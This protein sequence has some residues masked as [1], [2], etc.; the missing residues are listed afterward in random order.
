[1]A[2]RFLRPVIIFLAFFVVFILNIN[3]SW[4]EEVYV[5]RDPQPCLLPES[6]DDCYLS[7]SDGLYYCRPH[8]SCLDCRNRKGKLFDKCAKAS[9]PSQCSL[10]WGCWWYRDGGYFRFL[11]GEGVRS[12]MCYRGSFCLPAVTAPAKCRSASVLTEAVPCHGDDNQ[13]LAVRYTLFINSD[14]DQDVKVDLV[15]KC[16]MADNSCYSP[17][18]AGGGSGNSEDESNDERVAVCGNGIIERD[19]EECDVG[20]VETVSVCGPYPANICSNCRCL[21]FD[22]NTLFITPSN[23]ASPTRAVNYQPS[24]YLSAPKIFKPAE[25]LSQ[26][27]QWLLEPILNL[28]RL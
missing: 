6:A 24:N 7:D 13:I 11:P 1:M 26:I 9:S 25:N 20:S 16:L 17:P 14:G 27:W 12:D 10:M 23:R 4:A 15:D 8:L 21:R 2:K 3:F 5:Q 22:F 19:A 28:F 18:S